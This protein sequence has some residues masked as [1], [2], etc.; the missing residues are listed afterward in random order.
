MVIRTIIGV[1]IA[2]SVYALGYY[3]ATEDIPTNHQRLIS[4][5]Y[6]MAQVD[7]KEWGR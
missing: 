1:I 3:N 2:V 4:Q 6:N 5:G 7:W